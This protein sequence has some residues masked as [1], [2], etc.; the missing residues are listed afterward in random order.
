MIEIYKV[1][2]NG[3]ENKEQ[4]HHLKQ[5]STLNTN[6]LSENKFDFL[7]IPKKGDKPITQQKMTSNDLYMT[8]E[9]KDGL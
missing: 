8:S 7:E 9:V 1:L 4:Y 3:P 5:E 6:I 2:N